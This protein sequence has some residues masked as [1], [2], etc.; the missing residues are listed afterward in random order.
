MRFNE[1]EIEGLREA[2]KDHPFMSQRVLAREI[3]FTAGL[4]NIGYD[5]TRSSIYAAL[6]RV[7]KTGRRR[8]ELASF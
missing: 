4:Y 2:R 8:C 5:R 3:Y 7:E 6:R 1:L